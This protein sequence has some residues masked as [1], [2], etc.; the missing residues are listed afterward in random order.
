MACP[1]AWGP[2]VLT[3]VFY[4]ES[5]Y[6]AG[7]DGAPVALRVYYPTIDGTPSNAAFLDCG[8]YPLVLVIHGQC[9]DESNHYL[10]WRTFSSR[11]AR[12]GYVVVLPSFGSGPTPFSSG[13]A[14]TAKDVRAWMR[15]S[16]TYRS[17]LTSQTIVIGHSYGGIVA[18]Q[19]A[20]GGFASGYVSLSGEW[21]EW[22]S[23][24]EADL[25]EGL[26]ARSLFVWGRGAGSDDRDA[27]LE[28]AAAAHWDKISAPKHRLRIENANHYDYLQ[29][30]GSACV[31]SGPCTQAGTLATEV[32]AMFLGNY[33]PPSMS[34]FVRD[35][36]GANLHWPA[37][38]TLTFEQ[39]FYA[40]SH[41]M[42]LRGLTPLSSDCDATIEWD[43]IAGS[44][45]AGIP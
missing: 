45:S 30:S 43:I 33:F 10:R 26:E 5:T 19:V 7:E 44:G 40:G 6:A 27:Q 12:C 13:D 42:L 2:N 1:F 38:F 35:E 32:V 8:D 16:W 11:L 34:T 4:G 20:T 36:I 21:I 41:Q 28:G 15:S 3:P 17:A 25:L 14:N 31:S 29:G 22:Q 39:E 23:P 37:G 9:A 18:A 24:P